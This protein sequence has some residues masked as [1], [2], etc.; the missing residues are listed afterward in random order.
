VSESEVI[1]AVKKVKVNPGTG[2]RGR[3]TTRDFEDLARSILKCAFGHYESRL[4]TEWPYPDEDEEICWAQRAWSRASSDKRADAELKAQALRLV[5]PLTY[6][7]IIEAD[8]C[9]P[10]Y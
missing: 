8:V 7:T 6:L 9:P 3:V 1:R 10:D 2:S 4:C 5:S